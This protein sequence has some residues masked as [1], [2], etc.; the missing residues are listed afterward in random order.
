VKCQCVNTTPALFTFIG[1]KLQRLPPRDED[2]A[3]QEI[4]YGNTQSKRSGRCFIFILEDKATDIEDA[5]EELGTDTGRM[6][7]ICVIHPRIL[8]ATIS[9]SGSN[10]YS[11]LCQNAIVI[12]YIRGLKISESCTLFICIFIYYCAHNLLVLCCFNGCFR[13]RRQPLP[14]RSTS[15]IDIRL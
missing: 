7:G 12:L 8:S 10:L 5:D 11:K 13:N 14:R 2:T 3:V 4:L 6:Y 15:V 1:A 9:S